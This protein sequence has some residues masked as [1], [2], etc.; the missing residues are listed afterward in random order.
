M[1]LL[2]DLWRAALDHQRLHLEEPAR[3]QPEPHCPAC[4]G[5]GPPEQA[6]PRGVAMS[7]YGCGILDE[8]AVETIRSVAGA[9]GIVEV[10]CG[11]GYTARV[12]IDAGIDV[13]ATDLLLP[14]EDPE[15]SAWQATAQPPYVDVERLDAEAAVLRYP[16]RALLLIWPA[17]DD[18]FALRALDAYTGDVVIYV[19]EYRGAT[20]DAAFHD[21]LDREWVRVI[22]Q[23][24]PTWAGMQDR[25]YVYRWP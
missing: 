3:E 20:A 22:D 23:P 11:T 18:S 25:L 24:I 14:G 15:Q 5:V 17:F 9:D 13:V 16:D 2:L 21:A 12:L 1:N 7:R 19:G 4:A 8:A 10:G 6:N